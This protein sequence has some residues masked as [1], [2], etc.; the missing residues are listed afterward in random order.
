MSKVREIALGER[1][2]IVAYLRRQA[3]AH[4][5]RADAV[6]EQGTIK[7]DMKVIEQQ[8]WTASA[9]VLEAAAKAIMEEAHWK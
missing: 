6:P 5:Q 9:G 2:A 8:M 4:K 7:L 1:D 3:A